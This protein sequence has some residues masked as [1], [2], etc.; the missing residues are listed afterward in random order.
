M[1]GAVEQAGASGP[2]GRAVMMATVDF[3]AMAWKELNDMGNAERFV[4][5][6][7]GRIIHVREWGWVA[8][9]GQRWSTEDGER[10]ATLVGH[11][12]ARGVRDEIAA[13]D[14]MPNDMAQ[15]RFG[16]WCTEEMRKERVQQLYKHAVQSGNSSKTKAMLDQ[17]AA[18][19]IL[20][21]DMDDFDEDPLCINA[22]N[23]TLR[24]V[25]RATPDKQGRHWQV[26]DM[27]HDQEDLLTRVAAADY[28]PDAECPEWERHLEECLPDPE[29]RRYFQTLMGYG[30]TG[31]T[32]EQIFVM[33]QGRGGDG[34][35]TTMNV[36]RTILDGYAIAAAVESFLDT[37]I[38]S[39][40]D[41]SPDLM[42]FAGDT[43]LICVGEPKRG[44]RLAEER[45]KQFTGDSPI[46]ARPMYGELI[47]YEPRGLVVLECNAK[48]RIAGDDDGIW[49]R[50]VVVLFPRQF[51]GSAIE[52]GRK[53]RLLA[54]APG[55]LNWLLDG[56]RMWLERGLE[57]PQSITDAVE[58]YRRSANPFGEWLATRVDTSDPLARTGSKALYDDYKAFCEA[59]GIGDRDIMNSTAF[60]RAL[61]DRQISVGGKD[62]NGAKWRRGAK[63]RDR[64]AM[65]DGAAAGA[66][67]PSSGPDAGGLDD[68]EPA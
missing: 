43:R 5:H 41:A 25:K 51:K 55:I 11:K 4:A 23:R 19:D 54:E 32:D 31:R 33:L 22:G 65:F 10:L 40:A 24:L 68:W 39:G 21:R 58:E 6:A 64:D 20:N 47:E 17:A 48:P 12:V 1:T 38:R 30:A 26:E 9:D 50:I 15:R 57:P 27:P 46:Q 18:L 67:G 35:S 34:K 62:K 42:R 16:E 2:S 56:A 44:A 37:G 53:R 61:G 3:G 14:A 28:D 7:A 66:P 8:Y 59:D 45:V 52:K 36:I 60:G 29:V 49:R 63:L 13:L